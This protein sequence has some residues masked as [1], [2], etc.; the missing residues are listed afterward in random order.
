MPPSKAAGGVDVV[1]NPKLITAAGRERHRMAVT[2]IAGA[3]VILLALTYAY[4]VIWRPDSKVPG[5]LPFLTAAVGL[6]LG[7]AHHHDA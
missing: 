1:S 2:W 3:V 7:R 6:L 5:L 4:T